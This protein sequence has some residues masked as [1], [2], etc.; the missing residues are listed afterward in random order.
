MSKLNDINVS[1]GFEEKTLK[2]LESDIA[3]F[4]PDYEFMAIFKTFYVNNNQYEFLIDYIFKDS[5][6]KIYKLGEKERVQIMKAQDILDLMK[7]QEDIFYNPNDI[8]GNS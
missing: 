5:G 1:Y 2:E 6:E 3:E 4:G 8:D 7:T